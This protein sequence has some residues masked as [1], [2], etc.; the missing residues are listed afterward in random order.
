MP[1]CGG[2][3][4]GRG[5][6]VEF[7]EMGAEDMTRLLNLLRAA[8]EQECPK[9]TVPTRNPASESKPAQ[10]T[11]NPIHPV[12]KPAILNSVSGSSHPARLSERRSNLRH[13][14]TGG[15]GSGGN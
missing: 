3:R 4:P 5:M 9:K 15:R 10:R 7:T 11:D 8:A 12:K 2:C 13:K 1:S 6:G 14:V